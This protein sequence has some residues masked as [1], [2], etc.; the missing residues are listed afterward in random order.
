M[1]LSGEN[2]QAQRPFRIA[3][4]IFTERQANI[5]R[6]PWNTPRR[7]T[8]SISAFR[9]A[10]PGCES[11]P[12]PVGR[13]SVIAMQLRFLRAVAPVGI[14]FRAERRRAPEFLVVDVEHVGLEFRIVGQA[15][16]W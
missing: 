6:V 10:L 16:P 3:A 7:R 2:P 5:F 14:L 1:K 12:A 8:R 4:S 11:E 15:R 13:D 9:A